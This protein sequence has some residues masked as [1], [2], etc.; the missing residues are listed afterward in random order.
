MKHLLLLFILMTFPGVSQAVI[1]Y[2]RPTEPFNSSCPAGFPCQ[3]LEYY[4]CNGDRYLSSDKVNVTMILLHGKHVLSDNYTNCKRGL[5]PDDGYFIYDL[6][7]FEMIGMEPTHDVSIYLSVGIW[8]VNITKSYFETLSFFNTSSSEDGT[9][10]MLTLPGY[11]VRLPKQYTTTVFVTVFN[12]TIFNAVVLN[13]Y[14]IRPINFSLAVTDSTFTNQASMIGFSMVDLNFQV[15]KYIRQLEVTECNFS[16]SNFFLDYLNVNVSIYN[17]TFNG[18]IATTSI[19]I[20]ALYSNIVLGG[21]LVFNNSVGYATDI[22]HMISVFFTNT[23]LTGDIVFSNNWRTPFSA[24]SSS[25]TFSGNISFLNNTGINGG[26]IALYSSTLNIA[27][28]TSVYFYNNTA[29]ETGGAIYVSSDRYKNIFALNL[30]PCFYQL[31]DYNKSNSTWYDIQFTNNSAKNGGDHIYGESMHSTVCHV[32]SSGFHYEPIVIPTYCAQNYFTYFPK[33]ISSISSDPTRVCICSND[34]QPDCLSYAENIEVYPGE[35]FTLPLA[36]VGADLGTTVGAVHVVLGGTITTLKTASQYIQEI[37]NKLCAK[38]DYTI[39]SGQ[40]HEIMYLTTKEEQ[41]TTVKANIEQI[42]NIDPYDFHDCLNDRDTTDLITQQL[43]H[44]PLLI[45]ITLLPCPPGFTLLEYPSGCDCYPVLKGSKVVCFI[46]DR[47][48][49]HTWNGSMWLNID[50]NS[51]FFLAQYCPFDYCNYSTK[52][53]NLKYDSDMQCMFNRA[54]RLCGGC[55]ENYSLAIGS[56]H[57]IHCPNNNNLALIF[58]AAAGFLLVFFISAFNL[59]VDQGMINGLIFYANILWIYQST[60]FS[61]QVESDYF[62]AFLRILIAWLNL[63]FGIQTCFI[64]RLNAFWK[65][66]LQYLFLIYIWSIAGVVVV[67]ARHSA[68]LTK[69]VG[70]RAVSILATLFL[71]SYTKLLQTIITSVEFTPIR[72]VTNNS[73]KNHLLTVWSLDGNYIYCNFPHVLLFVIAILFFTLIWLPYT[74]FLF[75]MQW[76]RKKS[77]VLKW[78]S[79][80]SPVYDAYFAPL[81]DKHHYWFGVLLITRGILLVIFTSTFSVYPNISYILLM[82]TCALLLCFANYHR[83]YKNK[84]VQLNEN[85]FLV[86]LFLIGGTGILGQQARS[87]AMYT[88]IVVGFVEFCGAMRSNKIYQI[89][90]KYVTQSDDSFQISKKESTKR[91]QSINVQFKDSIFDGTELLF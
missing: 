48:G 46:M 81:K 60:L 31:P 78:V 17:T 2:V 39:F 18:N 13:Q 57:C 80:F 47:V 1:Y 25:I 77:E 74:L 67:A 64:T 90:A 66:W 21:E 51:T 42:N 44:T 30:I 63:D 45:N 33:S 86:L 58:F 34:G 70:N 88:S 87:I 54:G 32:A 49:Y 41:L 71:L 89:Y 84:M 10:G 38:L 4:L 52:T 12:R 6:E 22:Q 28:N 43:L 5:V 36:I 83:V 8:L 59:T 15:M 61:Q 26:A 11:D 69:L 91:F 85:F 9:A 76:L 55:K 53:V 23:T 56:S 68:K 35:T 19:S 3:T 79:K 7:V 29:T 37:R 62:L 16:E 82:M 14:V 72:V 75:S 73:Y 40:R 50:A 27:S 65:T 20:Y 24:Y